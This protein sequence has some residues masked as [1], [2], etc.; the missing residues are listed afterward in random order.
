[1]KHE[2]RIGKLRDINDPERTRRVANTNLPNAGSDTCHWLPIVGFKS[3]LDP[4][5]LKSRI[6]PGLL[7][8]SPQAFERVAKENNGLRRLISVLI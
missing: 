5:E 6:A 3:A 1:M 7:R 8:K 4:V 2:N